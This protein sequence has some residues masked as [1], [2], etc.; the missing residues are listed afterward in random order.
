LLAR[1]EKALVTNKDAGID[2]AINV[3]ST[4]I[5]NVKD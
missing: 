1:L 3:V 4:M 2:D 5:K